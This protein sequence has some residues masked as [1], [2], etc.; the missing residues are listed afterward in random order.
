MQDKPT[1]LVVDDVP[2][3]IDILGGILKTGY[4]VRAA[5]NGPTALSL[6]LKSPPDLILLD[7]MMPGMDGYEVCRQLKSHQATRKI[8]VIFV[9]AMGEVEDE[10]RGFDVGCVDYITKPV[11]PPIVLHRVKTHIALYDQN[12]GLEAQVLE[13]TVELEQTRLQVIHRLGRAG[14][15]RDYETSL[16]VIR[17]SHYAYSLGLAAGLG[18]DE[19]EQL[20]NAAPMHDVGKIGIPDAILCKPGPLTPE[21]WKIMRGHCEIGAAIIGEYP[22]PLF[23]LSRT[24]ALTHHEKWNGEGYPQGLA[25]ED[26]PLPGRIVALADV[27]DALTSVRPYKPAWSVETAMDWIKSQRGKQFDPRLVDAFVSVLPEIMDFKVRYAEDSVPA[28]EHSI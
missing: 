25:G 13:R 19:A 23:Q 4:R 10:S 7:I 14:E 26:I 5:T 27:F 18:K 9:T 2:E 17:M 22:H 21:E 28:M 16:H 20:L 3:N 8:P 12:R 15:Y 11:S 24:V 6:A 1:V